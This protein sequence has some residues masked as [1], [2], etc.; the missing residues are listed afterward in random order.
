MPPLAGRCGGGRLVGED[1]GKRWGEEATLE[2]KGGKEEGA[3]W[4]LSKRRG[5]RG[6]QDAAGLSLLAAK[7]EELKLLK[8]RGDGHSEVLWDIPLP[9]DR[10]EETC[11]KGKSEASHPSSLPPS[12]MAWH[13]STLRT[14]PIASSLSLILSWAADSMFAVVREGEKGGGPR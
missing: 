7:G 14:V 3:I 6:D 2:D 11:P 4:T 13:L 1:L 9:G 5:W 12:G 10:D 8:R